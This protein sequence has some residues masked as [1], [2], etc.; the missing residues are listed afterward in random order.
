MVT[1]TSGALDVTTTSTDNVTLTGGALANQLIA[2]GTTEA[3]KTHTLSG[4]AGADT[5]TG[6]GGNDVLLGGDGKD[7]ITAGAG[8]DSIDGGEGNDTIVMAAN[9]VSTDTI[10][11]GAGVDTLTASPSAN[12]SGT[13]T[14]V[15]VFSLKFTSA[16]NGTFSFENIDS[17][18][19]VNRDGR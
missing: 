17:E 14:G 4:G 13:I 7:T 8:K 16:D 3:G 18:S 12:Y 19:T 15:E 10:E 2:S 1:T 9:L 11:G 6:G 5:I